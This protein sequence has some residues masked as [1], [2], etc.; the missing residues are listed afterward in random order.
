VISRIHLVAAVVATLSITSFFTATIFVELFGSVESISTIKRLVVEP[1]L[2][3]LIP[4]VVITGISGFVCAKGRRGGLISYK[5][6]RMPIIAANGIL[7]L[8]PCAIFL[9][10]SAADGL[11]DMKFYLIQGVELIAGATNLTLMGLNIRDG[12][13]MKGY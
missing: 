10:L 6:K 13:R 12:L 8:V 7:V 9:N 2:F 5:M 4:A 11:F 1:G 3:I